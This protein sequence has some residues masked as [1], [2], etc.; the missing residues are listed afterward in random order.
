MLQARRKN[1]PVQDKFNISYKRIGNTVY[2]TLLPVL[3]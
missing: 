1:L 2:N 3:S